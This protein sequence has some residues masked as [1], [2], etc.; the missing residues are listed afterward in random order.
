MKQFSIA[1]ALMGAYALYG[2]QP[3]DLT[4]KVVVNGTQYPIVYIQA[5]F[6]DGSLR[7]FETWKYNA[8]TYEQHTCLRPIIANLPATR[9]HH[10]HHEEVL[11]PHPDKR[12]LLN[13]AIGTVWANAQYDKAHQNTVW[14]YHNGEV[15]YIKELPTPK[16][17]KRKSTAE[18][19]DSS[20]DTDTDES[21][22]DD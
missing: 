2:A 18:L 6:Q 19:P 21:K 11:H 8:R 1:I 9:R 20:S 3:E 7:K 10:L 5:W 22:R 13:K 12:A 15:A 17:E 14:E 4:V 16:P